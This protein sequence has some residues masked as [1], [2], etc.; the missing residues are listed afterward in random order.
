M[1]APCYV[2]PGRR[3][4]TSAPPAVDVPVE[5]WATT[6]G[7]RRTPNDK[8]GLQRG[9]TR[10]PGEAG[11]SLPRWGRVRERMEPPTPGA[12][13]DLPPSLGVSQTRPRKPWTQEAGRRL[14][15]SHVLRAPAL[16]GAVQPPSPAGRPGQRSVLTAGLAGA[17]TLLPT[18]HASSRRGSPR[19]L[20]RGR[21]LCPPCPGLPGSSPAADASPSTRAG[22]SCLP[23]GSGAHDGERVC[24]A[25]SRADGEGARPS[26]GSAPTGLSAC[27]RGLPVPRRSGGRTPEGPA[28][29]APAQLRAGPCDCPG[30]R[31]GPA[32]VTSPAC[33]RQRRG[34]TE[35]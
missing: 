26:A 8:K 32:A 27:L 28:S 12:T 3:F 2:C 1:V 25:S 14:H 16:P 34:G 23:R 30:A 35:S 10:S 24:T 7:A 5:C 11:R 15:A 19:R 9:S 17:A 22:G 31:P 20:S 4:P 13:R 33:M 21:S 29:P 6:L 18:R